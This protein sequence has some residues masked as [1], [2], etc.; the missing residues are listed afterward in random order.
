[1][2]SHVDFSGSLQIKTPRGIPTLYLESAARMLLLELMQYRRKQKS[3][4]LWAR[5]QTQT[6]TFKSIEIVRNVLG[7]DSLAG[8]RLNYF[9]NR[10]FTLV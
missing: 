8:K 3:A 7:K 1:M 6:A 10:I 5:S 4:S 2:S 9:A